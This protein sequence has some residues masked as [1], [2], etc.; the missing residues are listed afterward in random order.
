M[1]STAGQIVLNEALP[2]DLR[3]YNRVLDKKGLAELLR[4]AAVRHPRDYP[5]ISRALSEAGWRAAQESGGYGFGLQHLQ[6]TNYGRAVAGEITTKLQKILDD[7]TLS[8]A[9]REAQIIKL[10]GGKMKDQQEKVFAEALAAKNPLALQVLSGARGSKTNLSALLGSDLLYTDNR[11]RVLPVPVLHSYSEG[12]TP[13]EYW[14]GSYGARKGVMAVKLSVADAGYFNKKITQ[15]AH[16]LVVEDLDAPPG[17]HDPASPRGL[18]VPVTDPDNEGALLAHETGPYPRNTVLTPRILH[19]LQT[20]G[21]PRILVRSPITGTATHGG[22]YARDVG[23]REQGVLPGRGEFPGIAAAQAVSE[24]ISQSTLGSKHSGGVA[25][26]AKTVSGF[27]WITSLIDVPK[28]FPG[29]A[30]HAQADGTVGRIVDA[31]AGG[32]HV[33]V[34]GVKH[35]VPAGFKLL[36]QPG[37]NV[38]AGDVLS[39]G[40]PNPAEIVQ[41]K[42][43][44]E[45]RRYFVH[46]FNQ[47]LNSAGIKAHRRNIELISRGLI[48]HVRLT[49]EVGHWVPDDVVPYSLI[50]RNYAPRHD[51]ITTHPAAAT[52]KYLER[53][54]L[55]YSIG[56]KLKPSVVKDLREFGIKQVTV[57]PQPP[58]F[59][60]EMVRAQSNLQHDPD[61][62]TRFLGSGAK[63]SFLDAVHRGGM[64]DEN[65]SS[66]VPSL[67]KAEHFGQQGV[68]KSPEPGWAVKTSA[69]TPGIPGSGSDLKM[70]DGKAPGIK[71]L[72]PVQ[73]QTG[74][75]EHM[76][77][78]SVSPVQDQRG[79][80]PEWAG[81]PARTPAPTPHNWRNNQPAAPS[82]TPAPVAAPASP[83]S[84]ATPAAAPDPDNLWFGKSYQPSGDMTGN[85]LFHAAMQYAPPQ[86][87][88]LA[89]LGGLD[90][91]ALGT[92][93]SGPRPDEPIP[94]APPIAP[95]LPLP[96]VD[97][98]PTMQHPGN[99]WQAPATPP[100]ST[101]GTAASVGGQLLKGL[102]WD[103]LKQV[104]SPIDWHAPLSDLYQRGLT[105]FDTGA[106]ASKLPG[107]RAAL[108][109]V[110]SKIPGAARLVPGA[111]FAASPTGM[112]AIQTGLDTLEDTGHILSAGH[113]NPLK[114]IDQTSEQMSQATPQPATDE[115]GHLLSGQD[116]AAGMQQR[117]MSPLSTSAALGKYTGRM[118]QADPNFKWDIAN[119]LVPGAM[120]RTENTFAAPVQPAELSNQAQNLEASL[121]RAYPNATSFGFRVEPSGRTFMVDKP[122]GKMFNRIEDLYRTTDPQTVQ[123][124]L[125]RMAQ[126]MPDRYREML[127]AYAK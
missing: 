13:A 71:P 31:P 103:R 109:A 67:A 108:P 8:D 4:Q 111:R 61:F 94:Q 110:A 123:Q 51:A 35:Y 116:I 83:A 26:E 44:G 102:T 88:P 74:S 63:T 60:P 81:G 34:G 119:G 114:G 85:P 58:P 30:A 57:H 99:T 32:Q 22:V 28:T 6:K 7:D 89:M 95:P 36:V 48:D 39:E 80:L 82:S 40:V 121:H 126:E 75:L 84:P 16:R 72:K 19:H 14:A 69:V 41:Y 77:A 24:P 113:G 9:Q 101:A 76:Q 122:T 104:G 112:L 37:Q 25:G 91:N 21:H 66:Y 115:A 73:P 50:E 87:R 106:L 64:S 3:D 105:L 15:A 97:H 10:T 125:G 23:V 78:E 5:R 33:Y 100:A 117:T 43:I 17:E 11:D 124:I 107:A 65:S 54:V 86:L 90:W 118:W 42:G 38:E 53:P 27:D 92:L 70:G 62:M 2:E 68:I 47:A 52:N 96:A 98:N 45:G 56:T 49:G 127:A 18:P 12:L 1:H 29:G 120:F 20:L 79:E 59:V 55:H 93:T 46:A